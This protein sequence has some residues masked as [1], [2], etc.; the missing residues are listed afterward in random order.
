MTYEEQLMIDT[1]MFDTH[2][3][4]DTA[5]NLL[6][7]TIDDYFMSNKVYKEFNSEYKRIQTCLEAVSE[8]LYQ[9]CLRMDFITGEETPLTEAYK[10]NSAELIAYHSISSTAN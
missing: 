4:M 8:F 9:A 6:Q 7:K 2:V 1:E 3:A 10:H 5:A